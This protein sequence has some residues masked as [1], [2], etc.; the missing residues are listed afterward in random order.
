MSVVLTSPL[1]RIIVLTQEKEARVKEMKAK[2][3]RE[4]EE[5]ERKLKLDK[6]AAIK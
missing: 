4:T 1:T 2:I 5:E 3:R 6:E